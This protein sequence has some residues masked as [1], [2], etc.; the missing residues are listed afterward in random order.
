MW[1]LECECFTPQ[2]EIKGLTSRQE[3]TLCGER[4]LSEGVDV[5]LNALLTS[6]DNGENSIKLINELV[7]VLISAS[8]PAHPCKQLVS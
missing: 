4:S 7:L 2:I 1:K 6:H 5:I 3:V 8:A